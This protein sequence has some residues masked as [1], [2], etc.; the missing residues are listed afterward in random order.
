MLQGILR[1]LHWAVHRLKHAILLFDTPR[2]HRMA[3][4]A[5]DFQQILDLV[6]FWWLHGFQNKLVNGQDPFFSLVR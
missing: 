6:K 3:W 5:S 4:A 1:T 2:Y